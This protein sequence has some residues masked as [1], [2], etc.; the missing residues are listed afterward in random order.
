MTKKAK[1]RKFKHNQKKFGNKSAEYKTKARDSYQTRGDQRLLPNQI[2]N[3]SP[4]V[5]DGKDV[6][7]QAAYNEL[8]DFKIGSKDVKCIACGKKKLAD[9]A[10]HPHHYP[11]KLYRRCKRYG[12]RRR[13]NVLD[14]TIFKG[15]RLSLPNLVRVVNYYARHRR[16]KAPLVSDCVSQLGWNNKGWNLQ[17]HHIFC[18]LRSRE[19]AAGMRF[20]KTK[21][22]KRN[23][24]GDA[25]GLRKIYVSNNNIHYQKEIAAAEKRFRASKASRT[26]PFPKYW[27]GHLRV[28]ALKQRDGHGVLVTLPLKLVPPAAAPPPESKDEIVS[29]KLLKRLDSKSETRLFSDGAHAWQAATKAQKL[30][31]VKNLSVSHKNNQFVKKF[32]LKKK[33]K[34]SNVAGTQA[35]D[36]WWE[37]LD[38]FIPPQLHNKT[39]KGGKINAALFDYVFS[40]VWR[41]SLPAKIDLKKE[42]GKICAMM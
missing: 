38:N 36:R 7:P 4:S 25:H 1:P 6:P 11:G 37:G 17:V 41:S 26:K 8:V 29:S 33:A 28:A 32:D 5:M 35:V 34:Y 31:K 2:A 21:R 19:A 23:V 3:N 15:S 30:S 22:L 12:C 24:E 16:T 13:N 27:Q 39:G 18:A 14:Y 10:P 9:P 40:F 20:C 42:I